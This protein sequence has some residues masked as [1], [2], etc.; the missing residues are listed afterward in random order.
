MKRELLKIAKDLDKENIDETEARRLLL[1]L[2]RVSATL[3]DKEVPTFNVWLNEH[4][5]IGKNWYRL[6]EMTCGNEFS[7]KCWY[8]LEY[9]I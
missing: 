4:D 7:M 2:L 6:N 9:E 5:K 3:K 8:E 1:C